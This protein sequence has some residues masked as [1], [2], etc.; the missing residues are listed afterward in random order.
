MTDLASHAL[1][2]VLAYWALTTNTPHICRA[3]G[4]G[5]DATQGKEE[6]HRQNLSHPVL[7]V[8]ISSV[9]TVRKKSL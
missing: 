4:S 6:L 7:A 8:Y 2:F 1:L 3:E 9:S 5:G